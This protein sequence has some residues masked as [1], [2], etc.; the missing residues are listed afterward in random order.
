MYTIFIMYRGGTSILLCLPCTEDWQNAFSLQIIYPQFARLIT[1]E[2][3]PIDPSLFIMPN[4][5]QDVNKTPVVIT[6]VK[7][8][9]SRTLNT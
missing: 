1:R 4:D 2:R 7:E 8:D 5:D 3:L 6:V 9:G